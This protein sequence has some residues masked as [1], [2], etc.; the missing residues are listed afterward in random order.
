MRISPTPL[1]PLGAGLSIA[2]LVALVYGIIEAPE[3]GWTDPL[4][5]GSF[6]IAALA[7]VGFIWWE[8]RVEHPML[9]MEF[10]RSPRFSVASLAISLTFFSLFGSVFLLTQHLQFVLGYTPLEAGLRIMPVAVL[11][12][13]APLSARLVEAVGTKLVVFAGLVGLAGGL[14][15][16]STVEVTSGYGVV[17]WSLF[18]FGSGIGLVMPPATD[19]IMDS[20]PLAKAGVGSAM[21]DTTRMIGGALGVAVLGSVLA[22]SY[23]TAIEPALR[24]MPLEVAQAA[25]DSIGAALTIAAQLGPQ[26]QGLLDAARPAFIQGMGEALLVGAGAAALGAVLVLLLLPAHGRET[27][28]QSGDRRGRGGQ[29]GPKEERWQALRSAGSSRLTR[30]GRSST[31]ASRSSRSAV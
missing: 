1:D 8:R 19:S 16:L 27:T 15:L 3:R 6:G 9:R 2:G 31:D 4:I 24:E 29:D 13:A 23:G 7:S 17:A 30:P 28:L 12:V 20:L 11:I 26:G 18:V 25:G 10:F 22:A 5:L 21:N 14:M